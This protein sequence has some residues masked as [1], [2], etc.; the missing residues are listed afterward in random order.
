MKLA[1]PKTVLTQLASALGQVVQRARCSWCSKSVLA[2]SQTDRGAKSCLFTV[3]V[4][5]GDSDA[6]TLVYSNSR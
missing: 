2:R 5:S 6:T 3:T 1:S 4:I